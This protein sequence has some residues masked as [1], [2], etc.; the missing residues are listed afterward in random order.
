MLKVDAMGKVCPIPVIETKRALKSEEGKDGVTVLVDNEIATQNLK[1]MA[2]QMK[3]TSEVKKLGERQ[4]EVVIGALN[5]AEVE[6]DE[7]EVSASESGYIVAIGSEEMGGGERELG[8]KLMNSF[9]YSLTEQDTLPKA[10]LF[11]NGG[12]KVITENEKAIE[13]L[14]KLKEAGVEVLSCGLCLNYYNLT[15]KLTVGEITNMY[16]IVEMMRT[17]HTVRP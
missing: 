15:E 14:K 5:G 6:I 8:L 4:Y 13:D 16:K 7:V 10:I 3:L 9:I 2:D 11:F 17:H 12:V 1:K